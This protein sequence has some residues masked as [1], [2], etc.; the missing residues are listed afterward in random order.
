MRTVERTL[1]VDAA[2]CDGRLDDAPACRATVAEALATRDVDRIRVRRCGVDRFYDEGAVALLG[3]AG[4]LAAL[5]RDLDPALAERAPREP[6]AVAADAA[7]RAEPIRG[8]AEDAG[9]LAASTVQNPFD[10]AVAPSIADARFETTPPEDAVLRTARELSTDATVRIYDAPG[11]G[12]GVYHLDPLETALAD[13]ALAT[14]DRAHDVLAERSDEPSP[15]DA[16][17]EA[18]ESTVETDAAAGLEVACSDS[19]GGEQGPSSGTSSPS[20][21]VP[22]LARVLRK[23]TRGYGVLEDCFADPAVSDVYAN[24]PAAGGPL[25]VV[26]DGE[27]LRTNVTLGEEGVGAI[28]S[29]LRRTSGRSFSRASPTIDASATIADQQIRVAGVLDP[30]TE[31]TAFAFRSGGEEP[32]TLPALVANGTLPPAAAGLL[33]IATRRSAAGLIAGT[34]G[35]GKTTLLGALLWELPATTRTIVVEDTPE[36]PVTALQAADR[37]VQPLRTTL[38]EGPGVTPTAALRTGLRLGE[39]AIVLGEVR[40][41]EAAVL[42]EAMRVGASAETVL[43]T[44][45]GDGAADVRERVVA[46]LGVPESSFA[47]T[48]LLV[49]CQQYRPSSGAVGEVDVGSAETRRHDD[50]TDVRR[51]RR[52]AAIEEVVGT[53]PVR[54]EALFSMA[55]AEGGSGPPGAGSERVASDGGPTLEPTGRIER[56]SSRLVQSLTRPEESYADLRERVADRASLIGALADRGTTAPE[57]VTRAYARA[58]GGPC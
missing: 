44:I 30:A 35:A 36:L 54:F 13:P 14:L 19:V 26:A 25:W 11:V 53:D 24:G 9:L 42:Y 38:A 48:D 37:D 23:H 57:G 3:A 12:T 47:A 1:A 56:G 33:S 50:Q 20:P 34:R 6:L 2:D 43:G 28:A 7:A 49:T 39:S 29:R 17:R 8:L 58:G 5:A 41:E 21:P 22:A 55:A 27:H 46:D 15:A 4:R 40:G 10:P 52:V 45:H 51:A 16:V 18:L 31:G 32:L